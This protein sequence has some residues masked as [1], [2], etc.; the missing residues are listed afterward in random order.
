MKI[1]CHHKIIQISAEDDIDKKIIKQLF[2]E[3]LIP[4]NMFKDEAIVFKRE[5]LTK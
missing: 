3:K 4:L 5:P 1:G 2:R